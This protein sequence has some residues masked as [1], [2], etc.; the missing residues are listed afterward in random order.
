M[1]GR[2]LPRRV[3]GAAFG[4]AALASAGHALA[5]A[6]IDPLTVLRMDANSHAQACAGYA[7]SGNY[8]DDAI[9]RCT[10]ALREERGNRNN[11]LVT[12]MNRGNIFMA[13]REPQLAIGDFEAVIG[14]DERNAEARLNKGVA[15]VMLEQYGP[16]IAVITDSLSLGVNEPHKAY[17]ARA[18]AREALGDLRGALE[19]YTTALDIRPDWG[20]A[21]AEMQRLA[22]ARQE[23]LAQRL[24]D[25]PTP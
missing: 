18:A 24:E 4:V 11:L 22:E 1:G 16:A 9:A 21:D 14:I 23:Q 7:H 3:L 5:Q 19:D 17:Y 12:H 2:R 6:S 13:R 8:S 25:A 10:R 20:L 15:L